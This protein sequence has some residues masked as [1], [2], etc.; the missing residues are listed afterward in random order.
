MTDTF[1]LFDG[2]QL[3]A[4]GTAQDVTEKA[5]ESLA[6]DPHLGLLAFEAA[7]G[8]QTELDL[9]PPSATAT[10]PPESSGPGRPKLGVVGREVTL[11]P[12]HWDWLG[13]Q[14][15]GA[16][17][18]LR[19]LVETAMKANREMDDARLRQEAAYRFLSAMA[20]NLPGYEEALRALFAGDV[21]A[22]KARMKAWPQDVRMCAL[23][24][25][26]GSASQ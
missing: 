25:A 12:R 10:A 11:L 14:P 17:I 7:S 3:L 15:G 24:L 26:T 9:R 6:R 23:E 2:M 4:R 5:R 22:L 19:K 18:V 16:S 1:W 20:G 8:R 21:K 13:S